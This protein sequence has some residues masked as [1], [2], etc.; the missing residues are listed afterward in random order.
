M[1]NYANARLELSE[2]R[3]AARAA[4]REKAANQPTAIVAARRSA[5]AA[6]ADAALRAEAAE[7]VRRR[8]RAALAEG[9]LPDLDDVSAFPDPCAMKRIMDECYQKLSVLEGHGVKYDA[10]EIPYL[11]GVS[12]RV[13]GTPPSVKMPDTKPA[14][15]KVT[16]AVEAMVTFVVEAEEGG[17]VENPRRL[18]ESVLRGLLDNLWRS[19]LLPDVWKSILRVF[20]TKEELREET[21]LRRREEKELRRLE[22]SKK[23]MGSIV[24]GVLSER[25]P[26]P[27]KKK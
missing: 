19:A 18:K 11:T 13:Q 26:K 8:V 1:S 5:E 15:D 25:R 14:P 20:Q 22:A 23:A 27:K 3:D 24:S 7:A 2:A 9:T 4:R 6:E 17:L 10:S 16:M 21:A 12:G